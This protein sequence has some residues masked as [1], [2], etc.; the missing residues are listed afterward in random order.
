MSPSVGAVGGLGAPVLHYLAAAGIGRIGIVDDDT[1]SLSNLQ[2]QVIHRTEDIGRAKVERAAEA[3]AS[4]NPHVVVEG[5]QIRLNPDNA[6]ALFRQYH[7]VID[8]S[9]NFD[10]RYLAADTA[11]RVGVPLVTGAV[12]RF[13]GSLTV[14]MPYKAGADGRPNP[15][16]R[17]LF[18]EA[19]P[20]GVV[21]SC[22]EAGVL[23]AI[24]GIIG[25][26]QATEVFKQ[27]LGIGEPLVGRLLLVDALTMEF[28]TM[29]IRRDPAC[30]LCG[31][32]PT[33]TELI[34]YDQFCGTPPLL[35]T[36]G[37]QAVG[38]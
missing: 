35:A 11:A 28:R 17:D 34:D 19:P 29:R 36:V 20:A 9:D 32:N 10:T 14:L 18:P 13:D 23:G 15:S 33:V 30:P 2:R 4:L 22:A 1:V 26:I 24:T 16:Y 21:P 3:I 25:S 7:L 31:D 27:I 38:D 8:G 12:G 6:E 37:L 5:H